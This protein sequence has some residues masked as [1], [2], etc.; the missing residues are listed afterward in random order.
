[1]W[2]IKWNVKRFWVGELDLD[3]VDLAD[4]T[5]IRPGTI[6]EIMNDAHDSISLEDLAKICQALHRNIE[7][8]LL[9]VKDT[10]EELEGAERDKAIM[11]AVALV[12][13]K[14]AIR[15]AEK[16]AKKKEARRRE[17]EHLI[18]AAVE[19]ALK[20][21]GLAPSDAATEGDDTE[22]E[23]DPDTDND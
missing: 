15:N 2:R 16:R 21:L 13:E 9:L 7:E 10:D 5:D 11:E 1:M 19:K 18:Q 20:A 6:G 22:N 8:V 4:L 3:R 23:Q 14:R 12:R 17:E